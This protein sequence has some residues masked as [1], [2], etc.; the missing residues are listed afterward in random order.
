M[1]LT[2]VCP[3]VLAT[4]VLA[5]Q[6]PT[7][8]RPRVTLPPATVYKTVGDVKLPLY[9]YKPKGHKPSDRRPAI[10]FFF[11]GGWNGGSVA[12]FHQHSLYFASR[13]M[14]AI[15]VEYR[16]KSRHGVA[17]FQCV[18]D[19]KSA[20]RWTRAHAG[21][22]GVDPDRIGAAGGSAGGHLAACT[23]FIGGY[24]EPTDDLSVSP[25]PNALVLFNPVIDTTEKG[26]G[27]SRLGGRARTLSPVHHVGAGAPPAIVFH[28]TADRTVPHENVERF[29]DAM[30]KAGARCELVS[31]E[32]KGH[33]FFNAGRDGGAA[34]VAT[35]RAADK[36][37][38]SLGYL[39][40]PPTVT[41]E[42]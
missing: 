1:R 24:D 41:K 42:R 2:V 37:L 9:V 26:Y 8:R 29:R 6:K 15:T 19:A 10:L 4:T 39:T 12:Q 18:A 36:F 35:V 34:Y 14:V 5:A 11:G 17:P 30:R 33:G 21:T 27:A 13:G 7:R 38:A 23:A 22:L 20:L 16:V 28:G 25:K 32:G 3:L 31:F 40:G